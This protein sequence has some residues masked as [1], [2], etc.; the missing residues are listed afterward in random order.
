MVL[1]RKNLRC[2]AHQAEAELK[3]LHFKGIFGFDIQHI[4]LPSEE[5]LVSIL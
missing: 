2:C 4:A 5:E 1:Y 3:I